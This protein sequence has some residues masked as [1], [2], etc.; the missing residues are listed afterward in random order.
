MKSSKAKLRCL[1]LKYSEGEDFQLTVSCCSSQPKSLRRNLPKV[2]AVR[3]GSHGGRCCQKKGQR[4]RQ[5]CRFSV[6]YRDL[7]MSS[8]NSI[9]VRTVTPARELFG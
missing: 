5:R 8:S 3:K 2:A 7:R 6:H 9:G 1:P 4:G